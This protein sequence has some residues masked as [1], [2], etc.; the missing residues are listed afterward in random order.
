MDVGGFSN[1]NTAEHIGGMTTSA[2]YKMGGSQKQQLMTGERKTCQPLSVV[3]PNPA[4][5]AELLI[6]W[7]ISNHIRDQLKIK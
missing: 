2:R 7:F 6:H 5:V 3:L 1:V 4:G